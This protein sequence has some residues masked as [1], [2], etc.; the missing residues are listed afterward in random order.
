MIYI[1]NL[2]II[3]IYKEALMEILI[4]I[5]LLLSLKYSQILILQNSCKFISILNK[6]ESQHLFKAHKYKYL[7]GL[8]DIIR[9]LQA[10]LKL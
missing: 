9:V 5:K 4:F 3:L 2:T 10:H 6:I 1:N 8:V 7:S